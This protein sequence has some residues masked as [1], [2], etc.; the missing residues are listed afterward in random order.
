MKR[1]DY[2]ENSFLEIRDFLVKSFAEGETYNWKIDRWN[3]C[4]HLA[5]HFTGMLEAWPAQQGIWTENGEIQAVVCTEGENR[6]EAFLNLAARK[7]SRDHYEEFLDYAEQNLTTIEEGKKKLCYGLKT[8][9]ADLDDLMKQRGYQVWWQETDSV[10]DLNRGFTVDIP[11]G[12]SLDLAVNAGPEA[13]ALAHSKA[14][15]YAGKAEPSMKNVI[16]GFSD[17][18]NAPDYRSDLSLVMVDSKGEVASFITIWWDEVNK[19]AIVEPAGTIPEHQKKGLCKALI[20]QAAQR[21]KTLGAEKLYVGSDQEFYKKIGFVEDC[22]INIWCKE[23]E[24]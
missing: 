3:F 19:L 20:Y 12:F 10:L 21:I 17:L 6:G 11:E 16:S 13:L 1:K 8:G 24:L 18:V 4:R 15:G 7:F 9:D 14:F 5:Q 23:W 22:K 2:N